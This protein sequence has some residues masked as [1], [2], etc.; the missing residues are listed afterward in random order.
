M[1]IGILSFAHLHAE[2]YL[3]ALLAM[4]DVTVVGIADDN[5]ERGRYFAGQFGVTC[6]ESYAALLAE[7]PDA[8]IVC[9]ENANHRPLVE[10][11]AAAGAH[12]LCEKPLATTVEDARAIVEVCQRHGV[13]LMTAFPM[14]FSA[15]AMEVKKLMASG[16]LGR[17]YGVNATNQGALPEFHQA[18]NLPFLKR[19]WFVDKALA[20]GGAL[21]DHIVHLADLL[22][23]YLGEE[24]T[25]VYAASNTILH[26]GRVSVETGGLVMLTFQSG[27]FASLDCSWS[28]P[29]YYPTWG[30]LA[31]EVVA[32]GGLVTMDAFKQVMTVYSHSAGRPRYAWWGSDAN[33]GMLREFIAAC[34]ENRT[35][36]VTGADGLRAVEIVAA[37]YKSVESGDAVRVE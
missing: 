7:K 13:Q 5:A 27:A 6:F 21:A 22:R 30:G 20:G 1:R 37:A 25:E 24:V 32:E 3:G 29:A 28:K 34:R 31:M 36:A 19:D 26:G 17:I 18:E 16:G 33:A 8:V 4:P 14:R 23:W 11:A 12:V 35:P 15:P 2:S 9:S 10:M